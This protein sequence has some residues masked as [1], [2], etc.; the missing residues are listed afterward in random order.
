M[1][2]VSTNESKIIVNVFSAGTKGTVQAVN[3]LAH[4]YE[5]LAKEHAESA[6]Q[7]KNEV[8]EAVAEG[9]IEIVTAK[10]ETIEELDTYVVQHHEALKG[11]KGEQGEKGEKGDAGA[12]GIQ[13]LKGD[14]GEQ[15][16]QGIQG[17]QGVAG[18]DFSIYKTYPSVTAM[19][20]DKANVPEG[21]F[22]IISSTVEDPENAKLYVKGAINFSFITDMSGAQGIKGDKGEQGI[23]GPQGER[24]PK[25]DTVSSSWGTIT[26]NIAEQTDLQSVLNGKQNTI[27]DLAIIRD[28]ASKGATAYQK[29]STGIPKTD[30]ASAVQTSLGKADTALQSVPDTY[31]TKTYVT[32]Q[33][34]ITSSYHDN[35]KLDVF[36]ITLIEGAEQWL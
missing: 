36:D 18:K 11:D 4:Y 6:E 29:P 33:G 19:N 30:L 16:A 34:Y 28:G 31:A 10:D 5:Q 21:S 13:G 12:Q 24:G 35:T 14:K 25:G 8:Q 15:G 32:S 3:D 23:Q 26:G 1:V 7:S 17:V 20:N 22:V 2:D 9:L 27:S